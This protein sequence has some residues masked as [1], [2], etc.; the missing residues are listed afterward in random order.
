MPM[1]LS[2][3]RPGCGASLARGMGGVRVSVRASLAFCVAALALPAGALAAFPDGAPDQNPRLNT[4]NDPDFDPCEGDES[5][6]PPDDQDPACNSYF[7]EEFGYFGFSP[8]SANQLPGPGPHYMTG[9]RYSDCSQLDAAGRRA[10]ARA[11]GVEG[12]PVFEDLAE[13]LQIS[14]IR[15]DQAWKR[16]TGDPDTVIAIL[17]TGIRWQ[18]RELVDKVA[19]NREELE[20]PQGPGGAPCSFDCNGDGAFSVSDYADDPQVEATAGD[21]ESDGLL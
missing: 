2:A 4:P 1:T 21:A 12:V 3:R 20:P 16:S 9:T 15:A 10:N 6:V 13:C 18:E 19:L 8:D 11:E 14:G 17:D 7:E 5:E